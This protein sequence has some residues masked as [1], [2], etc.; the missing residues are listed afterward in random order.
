MSSTNLTPIQMFCPNCGRKMIGYKGDDG[1]LRIKCK[2][3]RVVIFS[4]HHTPKV[5]DMKI[6]ASNN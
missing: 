2:T 1:S 3:C 6:V 4:K 5:I